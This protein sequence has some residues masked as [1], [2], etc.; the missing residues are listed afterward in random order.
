MSDNQLHEVR[1]ADSRSATKRSSPIVQSMGRKG[2][3]VGK[4]PH[5]RRAGSRRQLRIALFVVVIIASLVAAAYFLFFPSDEQYVLRDYSAATVVVRTLQDTVELSGVVEAR[6]EAT[7]TAPESG[8][9]DTVLVEEG[10]WVV[11]GQIVAVLD[12]EDVQ[13]QLD[14][15]L[16]QLE[17]NQREYDR[18]LLQHEYDVRGFDRQRVN[19]EEDLADAIEEFGDTKELFDLGSASR[20]E[21]ETAQDRVDSATDALFDHDADVEEALAL[22]NLSNENYLDDLSAAA[23][24]I[25]ELRSRIAD[26]QVSSPMDGRVISVSDAATTEG[27][28]LNQY[29][30]IMEISDARDPMVQTAIEEQYVSLLAVSQ[31][32]AVEISGT[33][34]EASIERIGLTAVADSSGGT[35]TVEL[36]IKIEVGDAEV[37]AGTSTLVEILI[38]EVPDALVLPRGP[39]LTSGNRKYLYRV[40]GDTATRIEVSYGTITDELV[41]IASGIAEGDRIV[42]SSYQNFIEFESVQIGETK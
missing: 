22:H 27:A 19:L 1:A 8:I 16:R 36:D 25:A 13:D 42:T 23:E 3:I 15:A 28:V 12:A 2:S 4:D 37:M 6:Y 9:I 11:E 5:V 18:F 10:D 35:P 40:D 32:V 34:V 30:T 21:L 31:P 29:A 41:E 17:R 38:G 26:T 20:S 14:S 39:Y 24:D 33:R 7:V